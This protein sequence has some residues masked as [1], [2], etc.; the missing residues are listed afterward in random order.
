MPWASTATELGCARIA[1][2]AVVAAPIFSSVPI[3][4]SRPAAPLERLPSRAHPSACTSATSRC[5]RM[6]TM[7][8]TRPPAS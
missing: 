8:A 4:A 3:K 5:D 2:T 6:A 7:V 1:A